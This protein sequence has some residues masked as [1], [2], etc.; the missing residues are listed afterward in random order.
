VPEA[1]K[2]TLLQASTLLLLPSRTDSFGIVILEAWA[3][4]KPVIG[5]RAGG[6]PGVIDEGH[7]G[8]LVDF[9]DMAGLTQAIQHLLNDET[10]RRTLGQHGR[11]KLT[12]HYTWARVADQVLAVYQQVQ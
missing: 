1:E 5:S 10:L 3:H 8:L 6:I 7:N 9:G 12:T 11:A 4:G 2:H